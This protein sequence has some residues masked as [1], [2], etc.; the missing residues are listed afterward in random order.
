MFYIQSHK[1]QPNLKTLL[2]F[3]FL[4]NFTQAT[5][6][7]FTPESSPPMP[8]YLLIYT[9]KCTPFSDFHTAGS[10]PAS[11][12]CS[13]NKLP[14][15]SFIYIIYNEITPTHIIFIFFKFYLSKYFI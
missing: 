12:K 14:I 10:S 8:L 3:W 4:M 9:P 5:M 6:V 7:P 2:P 13:N 1:I 15:T 11:S